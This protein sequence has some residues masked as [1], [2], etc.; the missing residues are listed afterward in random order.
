MLRRCD[1]PILG[2]S[3]L[4]LHAG[5]TSN[6]EGITQLLQL[7]SDPSKLGQKL[8]DALS[9]FSTANID[10]NPKS[11]FTVCLCAFL[12]FYLFIFLAR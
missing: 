6:F 9:T 7:C 11:E 2:R 4:L 1:V 12:Y 8:L 5:S 3:G 10:V